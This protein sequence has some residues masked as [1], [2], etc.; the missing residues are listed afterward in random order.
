M[1]QTDESVLSRLCCPLSVCEPNKFNTDQHISD[2]KIADALSDV[3]VP[4]DYGKFKLVWL[5]HGTLKISTVK[6]KKGVDL[7]DGN[8]VIFIISHYYILSR[9]GE[10]F[11]HIP[12]FV[13]CI[14]L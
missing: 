1:L 8:S 14:A 7:N 2:C 4:G 10:M 12:M 5:H 6:C 3:R 9:D 11:T 13:Y